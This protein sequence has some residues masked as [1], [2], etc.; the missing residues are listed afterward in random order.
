MRY[1]YRTLRPKPRLEEFFN[2]MTPE[3]VGTARRTRAGT[4]GFDA[5]E[6][7]RVARDVRARRGLEWFIARRAARDAR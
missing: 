3:D 1:Y 2:E 5:R 6:P 7:T 4:F